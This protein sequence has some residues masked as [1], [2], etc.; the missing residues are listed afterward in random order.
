MGVPTSEVGYISAT[1]GREDHEIHNGHV[2]AI[3][4]RREHIVKSNNFAHIF[5]LCDYH[6]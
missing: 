2:V 1:A 5:A 6:C 3:E 4:R